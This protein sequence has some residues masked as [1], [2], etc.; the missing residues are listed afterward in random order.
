[1]TDFDPNSPAW[2]ISP[3]GKVLPIGHGETHIQKVIENPVVFGF[4]TKQ[5]ED[6]Y[7]SYGEAVGTEKKAREEIIADILD[8]GWI[9]IR[10]NPS[11]YSIQLSILS[12]TAK[13]YIFDWAVR[14]IDWV[15]PFTKANIITNFDMVIYTVADIAGG[16]LGETEEGGH[17]R[18]TLIPI[19]SVFDF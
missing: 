11:F 16:A 14:M 18:K 10:N 8:K 12:P 3:Q 13:E 6:I 15:G 5:I 4:T 7:H 1:M 9:R 2:W 17:E 19:S